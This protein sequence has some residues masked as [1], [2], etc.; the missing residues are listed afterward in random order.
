MR[1]NSTR[2]PQVIMT[3]ARLRA[4]ARACRLI[5]RARARD[6]VARVRV[7]VRVRVGVGEGVIVSGYRPPSTRGES[8]SI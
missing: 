8:V 2:A 6:G 5:T 4:R 1:R 3:G 7:R